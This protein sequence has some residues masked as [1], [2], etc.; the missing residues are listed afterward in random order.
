MA[1][2][3]AR[4]H[5]FMTFNQ[6]VRILSVMLLLLSA[7]LSCTDDLD[8]LDD[9]KLAPIEADWALPVLDT[10]LDAR[11]MVDLQDNE[12]N[13]LVYP[14]GRLYY[15]YEDTVR[16]QP[17]RSLIDLGEQTLP[18]IAFNFGNPDQNP[19][20]REAEAFFFFQGV[21]P[22]RLDLRSA[23]L[24]ISLESRIPT[25]YELEVI[26]PSSSTAEGNPFTARLEVPAA[27][28]E[29]QRVEA[30]VFMP[31][32]RWSFI[33]RVQQTALPLRLRATFE[34]PSRVNSMP[35][36]LTLRLSDI[37]Y[38]YI[39]G[40]FSGQQL[41]ATGLSEIPITLFE[42]N[43]RRQDVRFDDPR[44]RL[45]F[46]NGFGLPVQT[47]TPILG[48]Q[49]PGGGFTQLRGPGVDQLDPLLL[50]EATLQ[51][52]DLPTRAEAS[53][54]RILLDKN[55]TLDNG[56]NGMLNVFG[57]LPEGVT[58]ST[59]AEIP[60]SQ[61]FLKD[62]SRLEGNVRIEIPLEGSFQRL[63]FSDTTG[64]EIPDDREEPGLE[65][66]QGIVEFIA[67]NGLPVEVEIQVLLQNDRYE[68]LD[69][70]FIPGTGSYE[71]GPNLGGIWIEAAPVNNQG[72][73]TPGAN[74]E[75]SARIVLDRDRYE[76]LREEVT[77]AIVEVYVRS[78]DAEFERSV[79]VEDNN[80]IRLR[81][82]V[83]GSA[84]V[85]VEQL[86]DQ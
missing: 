35:M 25:D 68:P 82:G 15:L 78:Q 5:A 77:V 52:N 29:P 26:F 10:R 6:P 67:N 37:E 7:M 32:Q 50:D 40:L 21:R 66:R 63:V 41:L 46:I 44:I 61:G 27:I 48:G 33:D 38:S 79:I 86:D 69:T 36:S 57:S 12:E 53:R 84:A 74:T 81:L 9:P 72:R 34:D 45:E 4:T 49:L 64:L 11:Q 51:Q 14:D 1:V 28:T 80:Q 16:S 19:V 75:T 58:Y 55:N 83:R 43:I 62:S 85:D 17:A 30:E 73:V 2:V 65:G 13:L 76:Q 24:A 70:L 8:K 23:R 31:E 60:P 47:R 59:R 56:I 71:P 39:E 42:R 20:S 3:Y 54:N 18:P 22:E